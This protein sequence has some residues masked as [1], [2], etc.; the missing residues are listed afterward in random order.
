MF[1]TR[2]LSIVVFMKRSIPLSL[3]GLFCALLPAQVF[4]L[5]VE[6]A[7][8]LFGLG[9]ADP[10]QVLVNL[11]S[12]VLGLL[13][14]VAVIMVIVGGFRWMLSAGD[15]EKITK[16]KRTIGGAII[17]LVIVLLSWAVVSFVIKTTGNVTGAT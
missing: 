1:S 2:K 9:T 5:N 14:I 8:R 17:G 12:T 4:A 7:G 10:D 13:G 6:D 3:V 15:D 16:A 11:L